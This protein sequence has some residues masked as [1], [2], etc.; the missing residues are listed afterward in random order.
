MSLA[1]MT[2]F[3]R[4]CSESSLTDK[5]IS[6]LWEIKSVNGKSL[7]VKARLPLGYDN[8]SLELKNIA[9]KYIS[10]GNL[11][12]YLE[13]TIADNRRNVKIDTDLLQKLAQ[14]ALSLDE[15]YP[16]RLAPTSAAELLGLKGVIELEDNSLSEDERNELEQK[17]LADFDKLCQNLKAE[18]QLEGQKIQLALGQILDK[19]AENVA[20]IEIQAQGLPELLKAKLQ[21]QLAQLKS[22]DISE[23]RLAQE[24]VLLVTRADIREE[25]D[26]LNAHIKAA[27]TMLQSN[28]AIGRK[29]DFLCQELNREANT[30]CSKS[31]TLEI[32]NLGMELKAL[33]EQFREQ[34]QN[35]E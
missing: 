6:W 19:I 8:L 9:A 21:E 25:I 16:N 3:A 23:D 20:Q 2:G 14:T 1:S 15:Q 7:D 4:V 27:R 26:R 10:R 24:M 12:T 28:E 22:G 29:L 30:T 34:V 32:T 5:N 11:S 13:L 31:T 35:I 17:I 18:R 33:I